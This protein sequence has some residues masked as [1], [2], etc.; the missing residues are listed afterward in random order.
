[1]RF[2]GRRR[3]VS[4]RD[5]TWLCPWA[6]A[7]LLLLPSAGAWGDDLVVRTLDVVPVEA[8]DRVL[9][10]LTV[11][12]AFLPAW[13]AVTDQAERAARMAP[14]LRGY[15]VLVL[16]EAFVP[17]WV[18]PLLAELAVAYPHRTEVMGPGSGR[19]FAQ[20]LP[21]GVVILSRWPIVR[22][23]ARLF[24]DV[25][26]LSD[27]AADKGVAYAAVRKGARVFHLFALHAQSEFGLFPARVRAAQF[28]ILRAFAEAQGIPADELAI[29]A[30][31][32]NVDRFDREFPRA[33]AALGASAP[34]LVGPLRF[35][36]DA[37]TNAYAYGPPQA[38]DHVL[39]LDGFG[40]A[41]AAW[42]R[43]VPLRDRGLD[44]S[45]HY[46]VWGRVVAPAV[47]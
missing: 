13:V 29:V 30:G 31:D 19:A 26:S 7:F 42:N 24:G 14:H 28:A 27:C 16:Q 12:L 22:S 35:S 45:D 32:L 40:T 47:R 39:V 2:R 11:N 41:S 37:T 23:A 3:R 21:G 18:D 44:L 4:R 8:T 10:V 17:A 6:V 20:A 38:I 1:M 25:C 15:D 34:E 33:L 43:V 9:D 36:W 5:R 46:A